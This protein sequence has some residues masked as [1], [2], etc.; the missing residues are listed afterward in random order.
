[1]GLIHDMI[2]ARQIMDG[3]EDISGQKKQ[4]PVNYEDDS[5]WNLE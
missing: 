3:A 4:N 5:V 2:A 1:M